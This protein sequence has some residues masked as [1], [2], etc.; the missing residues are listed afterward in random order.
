M[1]WNDSISLGEVFGLETQRETPELDNFPHAFFPDSLPAFVWDR[2]QG[3][4]VAFD[5]RSDES[6]I[7]HFG[8]IAYLV[9]TVLL[10]A[11]WRLLRAG[12]RSWLDLP[13]ARALPVAT[14]L[15]GL[16][17]L[18]P[19]HAAHMTFVYSWLFGFRHGL[20]LILLIVPALAYLDSQVRWGAQG[21]RVG[22]ALA[23]AV[24]LA[25]LVWNVQAMQ[26]LFERDL[27]FSLTDGER[28]MVKWLEHQKPRP[29]VVTTQPWM[30]GA[31]SRAGYHWTLCRHKPEH[32]LKLLR[33]AKADYVLVRR[34]ER[35]CKFVHGLRPKYLETVLVFGKGTYI[36]KLREEHGGAPLPRVRP[37]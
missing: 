25:T 33:H 24:V 37:R 15:T 16:G 8:W 22:S 29:S 28:Q 36:L 1:S 17:M 21:R 23:T 2:L 13:A 20:P 18:A 14:V 27:K 34:H 5:W 7:A 11:A 19:V 12:P 9:P 32:T 26:T 30:F 35:D 3:V 4:L 10:L 31:F 6:Y